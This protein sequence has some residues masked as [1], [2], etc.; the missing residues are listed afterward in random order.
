MKIKKL[1]LDDLKVQSFVTSLK[2]ESQH[3]IKGGA[4]VD[5]NCVHSQINGCSVYDGCLSGRGCTHANL[6]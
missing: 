5:L 1:N 3:I 4:S 2:N 6:C